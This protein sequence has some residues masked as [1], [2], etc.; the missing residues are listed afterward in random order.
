MVKY[1]YVKVFCVGENKDGD[2]PIGS[3]KFCVAST[4]KL[5]STEYEVEAIHYH[6]KTVF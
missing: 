6:N 4:H 1:F 5:L 2:I 3:L